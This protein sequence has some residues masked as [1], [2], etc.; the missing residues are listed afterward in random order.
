MC[1]IQPLLGTYKEDI[2]NTWASCALP[3]WPTSIELIVKSSN[4]VTWKSGRNNHWGCVTHH[5]KM[6]R[7]SR[8]FGSAPATALCTFFSAHWSNLLR[9]VGLAAYWCWCVYHPRPQWPPE[10]HIFACNNQTSPSDVLC[11]A[12]R[13][14][15]SAVQ[16]IQ[17]QSAHP[18][19]WSNMTLWYQTC[20][21]KGHIFPYVQGSATTSIFGLA[22]ALVAGHV[23]QHTRLLF[24]VFISHIWHNSRNKTEN[25]QQ[26]WLN[27]TISLSEE[28]ANFFYKCLRRWWLDTKR[29][30]PLLTT[31]VAQITD[32]TSLLCYVLPNAEK[33]TR[34]T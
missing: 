13:C 12:S 34:S 1:S 21:T 16:L 33:T 29:F 14:A 17:S 20:L 4:T 27:S 9:T 24:H 2:L 23:L 26:S 11:M 8:I 15:F 18:H 7:G 6:W 22:D 25:T 28:R 19:K 32:E 5:T 30:Q 31:V 10:S 3:G